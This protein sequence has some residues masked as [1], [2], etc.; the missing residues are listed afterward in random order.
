MKVKELIDELKELDPELV[1]AVPI[2]C[3]GEYEINVSVSGDNNMIGSDRHFGLHHLTPELE[4]MGYCDEDVI[5]GTRCV[6]IS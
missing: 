5:E 2:Y 6:I 1:V 4:K 3:S